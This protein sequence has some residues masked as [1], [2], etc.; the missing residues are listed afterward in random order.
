MLRLA[1]E[2]PETLGIMSNIVPLENDGDCGEK[3]DFI[4]VLSTTDRFVGVSGQH[5]HCCI[6]CCG[7]EWFFAC[8]R[9]RNCP[10]LSRIR[11]K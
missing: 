4:G 7:I 3:L 1:A 2:F 9:F 6:A 5:D 8:Y 10:N 11:H